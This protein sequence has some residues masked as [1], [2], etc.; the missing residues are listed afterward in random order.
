MLGD[1]LTSLVLRIEVGHEVV[2]AT[3]RDREPML[4]G[5]DE[6]DV[7]VRSSGATALALL[8]GR[9]SVEHAVRAHDLSLQGTV[10]A[11]R[12]AE[13]AMQIALHG[14]VRAPNGG[15]LLEDLVTIVAR[16]RS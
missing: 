9:C 8:E 7:V 12:R 15:A 11:L 4:D 6:A 13:H 1:D 16:Q 5:G 14:I 2:V 3:S 10:S